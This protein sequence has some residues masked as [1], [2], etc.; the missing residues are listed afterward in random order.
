MAVRFLKIKIRALFQCLADRMARSPYLKVWI[1]IN[2]STT[3]IALIVAIIGFHLA[4]TKYIEDNVKYDEDRISKAWDVLT[5]M[6]GKNSNGGQVSAIEI[7]ASHHVR[8]DNVDLH[9]SYL[10]NANLKQAFLRGANF[11][12]ATLY[13]VNFQ[14]ADLTEANFSGAELINA[15]LGGAIF[16]NTDLSNANLILSKLDI[17]IVK[18]INLNQADITGAEIVYEDQ[19]GNDMWSVYDLILGKDPDSALFQRRINKACMAKN[20]MEVANDIILPIKLPLKPCKV[21]KDYTSIFAGLN[22]SFQ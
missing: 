7:L 19:Y 17:R 6:Q 4:Y 22:K 20:K 2:Q 18:S 12:G 8:L 21:S 16:T 15:N 3:V 14:G 5:R 9:D 1:K 10:A 11:S 13:N